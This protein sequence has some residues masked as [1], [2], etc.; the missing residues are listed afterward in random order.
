MISNNK[1]DQFTQS[2][3]LDQS[4]CRSFYNVSSSKINSIFSVQKDLEFLNDTLVKLSEMIFMS[5]VIAVTSRK[6]N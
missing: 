1:L 3:V 5:L 4:V 6:D 2:S